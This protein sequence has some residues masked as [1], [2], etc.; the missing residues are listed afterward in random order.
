MLEK[1]LAVMTLAVAITFALGE[2]EAAEYEFTSHNH[3]VIQEQNFF[4][5]FSLNLQR[6]S[7]YLAQSV[8]FKCTRCG[9]TIVVSDGVNPHRDPRYATGCPKKDSFFK[10]RHVYHAEDVY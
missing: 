10:D 9:K 8:K 6:K 3:F 1:V 5:K 2:S 4:E 7:T